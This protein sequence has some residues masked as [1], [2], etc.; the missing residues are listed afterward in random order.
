MKLEAMKMEN[1]IS[2]AIDGVVK[3]IP[4]SEGAQVSDGQA[5]IVLG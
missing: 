2:S 5:L 1:D 3:E 4:V